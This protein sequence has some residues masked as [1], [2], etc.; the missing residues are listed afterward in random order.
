MRI[1]S[2]SL[3]SALGLAVGTTAQTAVTINSACTANVSYT[4]NAGHLPLANTGAGGS[5]NLRWNG[6]AGQDQLF[7]NS[8]FY[9]IASDTR[10]FS[11]SRAATSGL[12]NPATPIAVNATG[13][14]AAIEWV[15]LDGKGI[16]ARMT[17]RVYS[18]ASA[19]A[20]TGGVASLCLELSNT[21]GAPIVVNVFNYADFDVC[22]TAGTDNA[23]FVGPPRQIEITDAACAVRAY[24][25]G[26]GWNNYL[27]APFGA[28]SAQSLCI[29][30]V[31][32]NLGNTGIPFVN[33][34]WTN[35]Y[36]WMDVTIAPGGVARFYA[37]LACDRQIPCCD[38][39]TVDTYC[40]GKAGTNGIPVWAENPLFVCGRTNLTVRNGLTGSAPTVFLGAAPACIPVP[41]FGTLAVSP[42]LTSFGLPAFDAAGVSTVCLEVPWNAGLC[43][44]VLTMQALFADG[45]AA[46]F[47]LAHTAGIRFT[48][49]SL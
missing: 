14:A 9:R 7:A 42:I 41:P 36:Q 32:D 6:V 27:T 38:P 10:E 29:N 44:A 30:A 22:G 21:T 48:I 49:G 19:A 28:A 35:G 8:W 4:F 16:N 39:A 11:F 15:N 40:N 46:G 45:G 47:P 17:T 26:C 12:V 24:H 18:T 2:L 13:D 34:D 5:A 43:G 23:V 33:G 20:P 31:V 25:L 37:G 3:L 1:G